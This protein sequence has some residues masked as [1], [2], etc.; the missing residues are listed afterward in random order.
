M[1]SLK[2]GE[3]FENF[4][5]VECREPRHVKRWDGREETIPGYFELSRSLPGGGFVRFTAQSATKVMTAAV[6][7]IADQAAR[8]DGGALAAEA[9]KVRVVEAAA[10]PAAETPH[11]HR[12]TVTPK[13][14]KGS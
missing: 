14:G 1:G 3:Y 6:S 5:V 12:V 9:R 10:S 11:P 2:Q 13:K 8:K 4:L 7:W